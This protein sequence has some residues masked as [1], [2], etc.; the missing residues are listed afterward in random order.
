[1]KK[2]ISLVTIASAIFLI[3]VIL[4]GCPP[5]LPPSFPPSSYSVIFTENFDSYSLGQFPPG[6]GG[7]YSGA[8]IEYC[9][10][11]NTHAYSPPY[12]LT[13]LGV[14]GWSQVI[15][16]QIPYP[17]DKT[18]TYDYNRGLSAEE[19][20]RTVNWLKEHPEIW[21]R[22]KVMTDE[23]TI[24]NKA[25]AAIKFYKV[26]PRW[27]KSYG[28]VGFVKTSDNGYLIRAG[29]NEM[30]YKPNEWYEVLL[31]TN[32]SERKYSVWVNGTLLTKDATIT[33]DEYPEFIALVSDHANTKVWFDD[34]EF[35]YVK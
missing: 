16:W 8:G 3:L 13:M 27:G 35:G 26:L 19:Y 32:L 1:M 18:K 34:I 21:I 14:N 9:K 6:W 25:S 31:Y 4:T 10:V 17:L 2:V 5:S 30:S 20:E 33:A 22:T 29:D 11:D 24:I 15:G 23:N 7:I 12:S 28:A